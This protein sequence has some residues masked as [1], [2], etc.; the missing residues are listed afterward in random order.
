MQFNSLRFPNGI[1]IPIQA[2]V[3]TADDTGIIKGDTDQARVL[4]TLGTAAGATAAGTL[5]GTAA[6][7]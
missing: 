1:T 6:G 3:I 4:K 5:M 7:G 2:E